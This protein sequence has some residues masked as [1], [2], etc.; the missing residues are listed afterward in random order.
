MIKKLI[1]ILIAAIL[2]AMAVT[3]AARA[4]DDNWGNDENN[5][6]DYE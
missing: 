2:G 5:E 6:N 4:C 3:T 1:L